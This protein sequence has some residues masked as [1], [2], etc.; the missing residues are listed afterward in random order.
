MG[1]KRLNKTLIVIRNEEKLS[2]KASYIVEL[3]GQNLNFKVLPVFR[4]ESQKSSEKWSATEIQL[5]FSK[6]SIIM[7]YALITMFSQ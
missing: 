2:Q 7:N 5:R 4:R 3:V 1:L 6:R